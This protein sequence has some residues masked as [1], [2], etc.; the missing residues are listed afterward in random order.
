MNTKRCLLVKCIDL[1]LNDLYWGTIESG[2]TCDSLELSCKTLDYDENEI[3]KIVKYIKSN[4][5]DIALTMNFSP[6]VSAACKE[7]E[8]PYASWIYD[9]PLQ[10]LYSKEAQNKT[11]HFFIFDKY[12]MNN[13]IERGLPNVNYLPLASNISRMGQLKIDVADETAYS[14]DISFVGMQYVDGR[15]AYYR[16]NLDEALRDQLNSIAFNMMGKWDGKDRIHNTMSE[17]LI[18]AMVA[19]SDED[20]G[21]KLGLPSRL[22]FEEVVMARAVAY[23]ERRLMMEQIAGL[24]PR[25]YGANAEPKDQIAG[26]DYHPFLTY[27]DKLPKAYNLSRINLSTSLHSIFSGLPLRTFDIIGAGGFILTNYQP[28][29]EELF[30]IGKEIVVYHSFEEMAALAKFF[31]THESARMAIL[32]AGYERVCRD[33]TY[34]VAVKKILDSVF[35]G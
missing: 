1:V 35:I 8:I 27:N 10:S 13:C 14:C 23:T 34:P 28:E 33:Y 3:V 19:L 15:Y 24:N 17:D 26:V 7:L 5:Y 21:D 29:T 25:W 22:Y 31:L 4:P 20:P 18:D 2:N 9:C 6:T 11:N 12:L 16:A 32:L 30:E